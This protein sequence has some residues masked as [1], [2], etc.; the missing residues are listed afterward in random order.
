[1]AIRYSKQFPGD[2]GNHQYPARFDKD[3]SYLGISQGKP[4]GSLER[5]LLSAAQV[6]EL[7]KFLG[8]SRQR[9]RRSE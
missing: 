4:D 8:A 9:K 7:L 1:M 5:V 2:T 3:G 6:R